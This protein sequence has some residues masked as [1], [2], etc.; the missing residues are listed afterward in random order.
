MSIAAPFILPEDV[1]V[2]HNSE[3][4][5]DLRRHSVPDPDAYVVTRLNARQV[6]TLI[7]RAAADLIEGFRK[8]RT[9]VDAVVD[10]SRE[11]GLNPQ[12]VLDKA[13]PLLRQLIVANF[14]VPD[15]SQW[16]QRIVPTLE[17][18]AEFN[19]W[20]VEQSIHVI[21]DSEV[22]KVLD[23]ARN[24][25]ALKIARPG[26][27]D[28]L[29]AA[30]RH[31][32]AILSLANR[33][34]APRLF[35]AGDRNGTPFLL[36]EW[37]EGAP[38]AALARRMQ[39][40]DDAA[41]RLHEL[42]VRIL[43]A[44]AELHVRGIV[45]GDIHPNNVLA[46]EDGDVRI[47]D[48]GNARVVD[49]SG[50]LGSPPRGGAAFYFDPQ[51]AQAMLAAEP[52]P[53]ADRASDQY[54]LAVLL[55]ELLVG[56][57]YLDFSLER[58]RML[59]QIVEDRPL[60]FV[61]HGAVPWPDVEA[62]LARALAKD[63]AERFA[64]VAAFADTI[65]SAALP[66][67][68]AAKAPRRPHELLAD[69][70]DGLAIEGRAFKELDDPNALCSVN[71]GA[72]GVAYAL[73]R[74]ASLREDSALLA[75]A[76]LWI[77]RAERRADDDA[78]FYCKEIDLSPE[79]VGRTSLFH[80]NAGLACV[81]ALI[82]LA[83]GDRMRAEGAVERFLSRAALADGRLDVTI[84]MAGLLLGCAA[85]IPV[86]PPAGRLRDAVIARAETLDATLR[87]DIA[88]LP[89]PGLKSE[90]NFGI[91]HGWGGLLFALLRWREV[92]RRGGTEPQIEAR[93]RELA[94]H[95][96]AYGEGLRWRWD[97]RPAPNNFMSGWCNGSAG[98]VHLWTLAERS[99]GD[100]EYGVLARRCGLYA[101]ETHAELGDLC[102]GAGGSAYAMLDLY[103]HTG[104]AEWLQR[105]R[106]L[107]ERAATLIGRWALRRD[108]LYKG[109]VG[110][111]LLIADLERPELSCMPLFDREP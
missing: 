82:A 100:A 32:A 101:F 18:G 20:T 109:E 65:S 98:L 23:S 107:A 78:A 99:F 24:F 57:S 60:P 79:Q 11:R 21:E 54:C 27:E 31:E 34:A 72:A 73:Y 80:S 97:A 58:E 67:V 104:D 46:T 41:P 88:A 50:P 64:S 49:D 6:S 77:D 63:P 36:S 13:F 43:R 45:Q 51:H 71:S 10:F 103:R 30:L 76:E 2:F 59:R 102:C 74:I 56:Q 17:T 14:L 42:C 89:A 37:C 110:I 4:S 44:Y 81:E 92:C 69:S 7:D 95:G 86:L 96:E 29:G 68:P 106:A 105:A 12:E 33:T 91:A 22:Y 87:N 83:N 28:R 15:G 8:A 52:P 26:H 25:A 108:S 75:L 3:L 94:E 62:A 19:G 66:V 53:P 70:L 5:A 38:V 9:I 47:L 48:F 35:E 84:G 111:A 1:V 61:H 85:L 93:L 40:A 90:L 39:H 55:R 16:A